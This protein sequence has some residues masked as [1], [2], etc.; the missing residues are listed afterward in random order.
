MMHLGDSL[1]EMIGGMT[2]S[3]DIL[4][5]APLNNLCAII[6][7]PGFV[8]FSRISVSPFC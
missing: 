7:V 6:L 3:S 4:T 8:S 5:R 1:A 2:F